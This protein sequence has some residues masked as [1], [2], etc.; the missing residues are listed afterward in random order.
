MRK[1]NLIG[2]QFGYLLVLREDIEKTKIKRASY[3][4]CQC[5]CGKEV[6]VCGSK[7]KAGLTQ[8]CG[9]LQKERAS[10]ASRIDLTGQHFNHLT[11]LEDDGLI[12]GQLFWKCQCDCGKIISVRSADIRSGHTKSCG[13]V[14]S[15]GEERII[16]VLNELGIKFETQK[17]FPNLKGEHN[18]QLSYD[19]YLPEL[20]ILI[21]CQGKQHYQSIKW[22]GGEEKFIEQQT[23]D[24]RKREYCKENNYSLI[25][26]SYEDYDKISKDFL[27]RKIKTA[28]KKT[29]LEEDKNGKFQ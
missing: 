7:L 6:S 19:F 4:F 17:R 11:V 10:L 2:Q 25:E 3:W 22:Y 20:S 5:K 16:K 26:I 13:C 1:L 28:I 15:F 24:L 27:E 29:Y 14:K 9:C 23:H 21:E 8:S 12:N 18:G